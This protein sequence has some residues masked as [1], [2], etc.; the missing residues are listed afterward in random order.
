METLLACRLIPLDKNPRL[1]PIGT[2]KVLRGVAGKVVATHIRTD[3]ITPVGSLQVCAVQ[4]ADNES[5]IRAM[6]A[7]F[8]EDSFE[9]VL[10]VD[11]SNAFNSVN[12]NVSSS[13]FHHISCNH[14][15]CEELL[16]C[17]PT[18]FRHREK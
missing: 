17:S 14:H 16:L 9:T 3:I 18:A 10:L 11:A 15:I 4:E 5:T 12:R 7:I 6:Y 2:G 8:N 13:C 1:R